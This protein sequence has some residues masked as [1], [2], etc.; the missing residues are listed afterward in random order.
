MKRPSYNSGMHRLWAPFV[1]L[2]L[3][4]APQA[5]LA[6]S[7]I[8]LFDPEWQLVPEASELDP[9]CPV[10]A[11]LGFGGTLQLI[12]NVMNASISFGIVIC[13]IVIVFA[14]ILWLLTPTNPENHSQ[15]K[16]V[17][18]NAVTGFLIILSAWLIVDFVMK[19]LY[20]GDSTNFGPWNAIL[21]GG[22][23]CVT[24]NEDLKPLF[25]GSITAIPGQGS[26]GGG[27]APDPRYTT[28]GACSPAS[29]QAAAAQ[30][31]KNMST[32][33]ARFFAC[34]A[35]PESQC[36]ADLTNYNWGRGSSA[37]GPFQIL[38]DGNSRYFNNPTCSQAAGIT[39][40]LNCEAGFRG[41]N[42]IPGSEI[43]NRCMRAA[44]NLSCSAVA[45]YELFKD[46]G[47]RPWTGN[48]D[49]SSAH[50]R[51]VREL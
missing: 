42:P 13:V 1:L 27:S 33:E 25:D 11:P 36:G 40:N 2:L 41:G 7:G 50:M 48:K 15:A 18:T 20:D 30:G 4:C 12:Q 47:H 38:L 24:A 19:L 26:S 49:S 17:L 31:G 43:A 8:P 32:N 28:R 3:L 16:K 6:Q 22:D 39:G 45:A 51:C 35:R 46:S 5:A 21:T 10:G 9:S 14:G 44:A 29:V 37:Y 23:I 34:I